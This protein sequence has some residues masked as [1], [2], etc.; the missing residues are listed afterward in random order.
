ME[1]WCPN[2]GRLNSRWPEIL[3]VLAFA[4]LVIALDYELLRNHLILSLAFVMFFVGDIALGLRN[5]SHSGDEAATQGM[6]QRLG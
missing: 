1:R 3:M 2:C 4:V 6:N 5:H